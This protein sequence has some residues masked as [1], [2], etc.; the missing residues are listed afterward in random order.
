MREMFDSADT[1]NNGTL[2]TNELMKL[3]ERL[4]I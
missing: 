1:D 2:D 3:F 4:G